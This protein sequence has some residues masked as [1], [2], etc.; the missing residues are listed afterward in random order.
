MSCSVLFENTLLGAGLMPVSACCDR[1]CSCP[2]GGWPTN[3]S[4][5]ARVTLAT[6]QPL[7]ILHR[8]TGCQAPCVHRLTHKDFVEGQVEG[9]SHSI[10][11][12][13]DGLAGGS[14]LD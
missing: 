3:L 14:D 9:C 13:V 4:L 2:L 7:T 10:L 6:M 12:C 11:H 5:V 1:C 8:G